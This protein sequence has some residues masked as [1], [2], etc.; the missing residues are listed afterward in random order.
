MR[1]QSV[2]K[3]ICV[4]SLC[5]LYCYT[6]WHQ[7][8]TTTKNLKKKAVDLD[9]SEEIADSDIHTLTYNDIESQYSNMY[10]N[11]I[12]GGIQHVETWR[13]KQV[14][15]STQKDE[16]SQNEDLMRAN[17]KKNLSSYDRLNATMKSRLPRFI[18][19]GV[20]KCGTGT[21]MT[22]VNRHPQIIRSQLGGFFAEFVSFSQGT[23]WYYNKMVVPT[24]DHVVLERCNGCYDTLQ[25][26]WRL[27]ETLGH[28][29][30]IIWIVRD[31]MD[32]LESE[33]A[34]Q[35]SNKENQFTPEN[36]LYKS[37]E[38]ITH[39]QIIRRGLYDIFL[40]HWLHYLPLD[41]FL[42]IE[43]SDFIKKPWVEL[44]RLERFMNLTRFFNEDMFI[45][46]DGRKDFY[47]IRNTNL[48]SKGEVTCMG[49]GKGREHPKFDTETAEI[50]EKFYL[51]H[52]KAFFEKIQHSY[53]W[54]GT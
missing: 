11:A 43:T 44:N 27:T 22:F 37:K 52:S 29:V 20:K 32:R 31:P 46:G 49:D 19:G 53:K 17:S 16:Y 6:L 42:F 30:Y 35:I 24:K 39:N 5:A 48:T 38:N 25:A 12:D 9:G 54:R 34:Q 8:K 28:D 10:D 18:L 23:Q 13:N 14:K 21:L 40:Q 3:T 7:H 47:C 45:P 51:P 4:L 50:L 15:D 36:I 1:K 2:I 26:P 33:I 41:H